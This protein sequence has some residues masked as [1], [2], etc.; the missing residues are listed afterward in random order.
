MCAEWGRGEPSW[1]EQNQTCV[2]G[3]RWE[4][5]AVA[6]D[7]CQCAANVRGKLRA[8]WVDRPLWDVYG[9]KV[10]GAVLLSVY[11]ACD[12]VGLNSYETLKATVSS[13]VNI[14]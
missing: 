12:K 11:A 4:D 13:S 5:E 8:R 10:S 1:G 6:V 3:R 14:I 9:P 2:S 7:S